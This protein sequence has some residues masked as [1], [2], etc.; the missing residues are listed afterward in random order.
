MV[1]DNLY[2]NMDYQDFL[3][4]SE[5]I[6]HKYILIHDAKCVDCDKTVSAF[7]SHIPRL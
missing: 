2:S 5:I 3:D 4:S 7:Y 6:S 1:V